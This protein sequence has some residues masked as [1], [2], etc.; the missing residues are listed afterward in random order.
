MTR[1][2]DLF[3]VRLQSFFLYDP[4]N[5][6]ATKHPS[7]L[8]QMN[9]KIVFFYPMQS[10][11]NEMRNLIGFA[12][13][14]CLF[15]NSFRLDEDLSKE[16]ER[17]LNYLVLQHHLFLSKAFDDRRIGVIILQHSLSEDIQ[18]LHSLSF[19]LIE[20]LVDRFFETLRIWAGGFSPEP[21]TIENYV[22]V[23]EKYFKTN[24]SSRPSLL[25]LG[26]MFTFRQSA[27]SRKL[28]LACLQA[29][30]ELMEACP[31]LQD[32][33][34]FRESRL[35]FSTASSSVDVMYAQQNLLLHL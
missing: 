28:S 35:V 9:A 13:G 22:N 18:L 21:E 31:S 29:S 19:E 23:I 20:A 26:P 6:P 2:I 7:E 32:L 5:V 12:E 16:P 1:D 27:E 3:N 8:E 24:Q 33:L 10:D 11:P 17:E 4:K 34:F 14:V 30:A 15:F 25:G